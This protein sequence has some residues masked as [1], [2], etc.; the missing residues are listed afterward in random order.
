LIANKTFNNTV[1][2]LIYFS[3]QF[4]ATGNENSSQ[5]TSLQC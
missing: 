4:V 2:L 3:D 5:Q 1:L